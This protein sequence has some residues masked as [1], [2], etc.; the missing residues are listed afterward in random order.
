VVFPSEWFE[1][2]PFTVMET[3]TMGVPIIAADIGGVPELVEDGVNG[4]LFESGNAD[5]LSE[6]IKNLWDN[7][8]KRKAY[9][10]ACQKTSF[11]TPLEYCQKL[12]E[13]LEQL[14]N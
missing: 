8:E 11:L 7:A 5:E 12:L 6:K 10:T 3:L 13:T 2:C 9:R 14:N 4:E 1:N